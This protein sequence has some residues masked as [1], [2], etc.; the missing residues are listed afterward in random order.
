MQVDDETLKNLH[1][2]HIMNVPFE[3]LDIHYHKLFDLELSNIYSKVVDNSR[4]G[5]C[6]ELNYLFNSFLKALGFS[7]KIISSRVFDSEG[8][9][10]PEFDHMSIYVR[11]E[12]DYIADVGFGDLFVRPLEIKEGVQDD[13]RNQFLI[14]PNQRREYTLSMS[15]DGLNFQKKYVFSLK[16]VVEYFK[17][18]CLDKQT[19][20]ESYFVKNMVCTLATE[21]GRVTLFNDKLIRKTYAERSEISILSDMDL[22]IQLKENF[23]IEIR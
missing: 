23:N 3:N 5:F 8:I 14:E 11:T 1:R 17:K 10:G 9:P 12:R 2:H 4:G 15:S 20:P 13:G 16:E 7:T 18:P 22:Q 21:S 6:C 19:N